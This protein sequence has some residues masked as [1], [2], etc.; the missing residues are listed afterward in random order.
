[1]SLPQP[2]VDDALGVGYCAP[3]ERTGGRC[4]ESVLEAGDTQG[5]V[6]YEG[7]AKGDTTKDLREVACMQVTWKPS[8][9]LMPYPGITP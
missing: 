4:S 2:I 9:K 3:L 1:M 8:C 5:A 7:D 6:A